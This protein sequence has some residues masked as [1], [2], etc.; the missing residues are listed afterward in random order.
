MQSK[1]GE[2]A[3]STTLPA[4]QQRPDARAGSVWVRVP[5]HLPLIFLQKP[6]VAVPAHALLCDNQRRKKVDP[7]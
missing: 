1:C 5:W 2:H 4:Q 3:L 6:G 7:P